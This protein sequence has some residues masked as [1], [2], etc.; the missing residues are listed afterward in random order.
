LA[1]THAT[2]TLILGLLAGG[3]YA[4]LASGL[5]LIFGVM[6][7][8]NV[9]QGA[10]LVLAALLTFELWQRLGLDPI[11]A[12][13]VTTPV[14][15]AV[16]WAIYRLFVARIRTAPVSMTVL[17]MFALAITIEGG[18]GLVW[19]NVFRSVT[20]SYFSQSLHLGAFF[21]PKAQVFGCIA[22]AVVLA[23]LWL[24]LTRTWAGRAIR[25]ASQNPQGSALVGVDIRGVAALTFAVGVATTGAGGSILSVLYTL[26]PASHYLWISRL[27]GIVVLGGMGSLPGA[28]AG[29]LILGVAEAFTA[30]YVST[31]WATVVFYVVILAVLLVRPQGLMGSRLRGDVVT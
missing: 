31:R 30:T 24:L 16:G 18:M 5:T 9:A 13:L 1:V 11:A 27:L 10:M 14:M 28:V 4:L 20:P 8:I 3:V 19:K 17:L 25:A 22:A 26:F 12:A 7:I 29:A 2:E 23:A 21:F 6:G 15:F